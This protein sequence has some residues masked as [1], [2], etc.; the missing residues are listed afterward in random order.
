MYPLWILTHAWLQTWHK[1]LRFEESSCT[2]GENDLQCSQ[3]HTYL[4]QLQHRYQKVDVQPD[5]LM[6]WHALTLIKPCKLGSLLNK[7]WR[8]CHG[9]NSNIQ[10]I[11][12]YNW[13]LWGFLNCPSKRKPFNKKRNLYGKLGYLFGLCTC[14]HILAAQCWGLYC[15]CNCSYSSYCWKSVFCLVCLKFSAC[16]AQDCQ[17]L[18]FKSHFPV[19]VGPD[20][21]WSIRQCSAGAWQRWV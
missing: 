17:V 9:F 3:V 8:S 4:L 18:K 19:T 5:I 21:F 7:Y 13:C 6:F 12:I 11:S 16:I 15:T 1:Q 20:I 2:S 10:D 14:L